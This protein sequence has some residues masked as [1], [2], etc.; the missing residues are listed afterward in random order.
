MKSIQSS[1]KPLVATMLLTCLAC[2]GGYTVVDPGPPSY[3]PA[4]GY[5]YGYPNDRVLLVWDPVIGAYAVTGY[6]HYYYYGG[7]YYRMRAGT[8]YRTSRLDGP[9]HVASYKSVPYGLQKKYYQEKPAKQKPVKY[10]AGK[11]KESSHGHGQAQ[12]D[13]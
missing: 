13:D 12:K 5:R 1:F 3:A 4:Y 9:W 10:K 8:W 6:P 7:R 2:G 11:G